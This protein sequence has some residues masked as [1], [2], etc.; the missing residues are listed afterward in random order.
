MHAHEPSIAFLSD[1]TERLKCRP[2]MGMAALGG[3][4]QDVGVEKDLHVSGL[5]D[6][7]DS[8]DPNVVEHAVPVG[9]GSCGAAMNP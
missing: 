9:V 2:M 3:G 8:L 4:D 5:Q 1:S 7:S 6:C